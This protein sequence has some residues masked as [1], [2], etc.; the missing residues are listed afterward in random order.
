[1]VQGVQYTVAYVRTS[2][3]IQAA[4]QDIATPVVLAIS[5]AA[6]ASGIGGLVGFQQ[7]GLLLFTQGLLFFRR[8]KRLAFGVVYSW[9][10]K[11]PID[12][13]L[14]RLVDAQTGRTVVNRVTDRQGR[15]L[16]IAP[17]GS[18]RLEIRK[19]GY[20][21][22]SP[23]IVRT[24]GDGQYGDLYFGDVLS[25]PEGGPVIVNVPIDQVSD[26][27][28]N[29]R[30]TRDFALARLRSVVVFVGP[31]LALVSYVLTPKVAQ[32]IVLVLSLGL[33]AVF[34]R[35]SRPRRPKS[36]GIVRDERGRPLANAIVRIVETGYDKVLE[37]AMTDAR[38][39]YAF[40]VGRNS[41]YLRFD[42]A[43]YESLKSGVLD[44]RNNQK[45]S[46]AAVDVRLKKAV[47]SP[48]SDQT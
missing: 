44:F 15:F 45:A 46:V 21:F 48:A 29:E 13:A 8:R 47:V 31:A 39:R 35:F 32:L 2:Q 22:P 11:L 18:Y 25:L 1:M 7:F 42:K 43:G 34:L 14:V 16:I 10:T 4:N 38:G 6:V 37:S 5:V 33:V 19:D 9:S 40:L 36:W 23:A 12:L 3:V 17:P 24:E 30:I 41:Y 26:Q 20:A 27:R 28:L